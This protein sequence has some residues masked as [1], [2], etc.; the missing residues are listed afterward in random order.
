[1]PV[2]YRLREDIQGLYACCYNPSADLDRRFTIMRLIDYVDLCEGQLKIGEKPR[3]ILF[4]I[5]P[6]KSDA[7]AAI[8]TMM[9][10][11]SDL[12]RD[13]SADADDP[14]VT[15]VKK[16]ILRQYA[17]NTPVVQLD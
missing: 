17:S 3:L 8:L 12:R 9:K 4:H 11:I 15:A 1:M 7:D 10:R 13:Q 16:Q 14:T 2:T 6:V 5:S